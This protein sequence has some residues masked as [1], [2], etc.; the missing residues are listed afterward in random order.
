MRKM[1]VVLVISLVIGAVIALRAP[2]EPFEV[3]VARAD[4]RQTLDLPAQTVQALPA[5]TLAPLLGYAHRPVL[6]F[7]AQAALIRYT[8]KAAQVIAL[9]G[10]QAEFQEILMRYGTAVVPPIHYYLENTSTA[11]DVMHFTA[12]Q[13]QQ[14]N[15]LARRLWNGAP[16]AE[17]GDSA[18]PALTPE[19]RGWYAVGFIRDEGHDFLGQFV[20]DASGTVQR[21]QSERVIEGTTGF[22]TS[23]LRTL[24]RKYLSDAPLTAGDYAWAGVD[25]AVMAGAVKLLRA[26]KAAATGARAG[27]TAARSGAAARALARTGRIGVRIAKYGA[28]PAAVV[29]AVT[30]PSAV[31]GL[32]HDAARALGVPPVLAI[33]GGWTLLLLP[34]V[35]IG[36]TL[37]RY[38]VRPAI[39][40]LRG[41]AA[42]LR[43]VH[44]GGWRQRRL[45]SA[46]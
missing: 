36:L 32:L 18:H 33:L 44:G 23:G 2:A 15:A 27:T 6:L 1:L 19:L 11:L 45:F 28:I 40:L 4:A 46:D 10:E 8:D 34:L 43:W 12:G 31:T 24:E 22:F 25:L 26:G 13:I 42:A 29:L 39:A 38:L 14:A 21:V 17:A 37:L 5:Q 41:L 16:V 30:H 9:Y 35:F 20:V 7:S 3:A